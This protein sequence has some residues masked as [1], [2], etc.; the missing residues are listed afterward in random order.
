ML[1][2]CM[3]INDCKILLWNGGIVKCIFGLRFLCERALSLVLIICGYVWRIGC[4]LTYGII[5]GVNSLLGMEYD[6]KFL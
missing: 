5:K 4:N 1:H 3:L 6:N 2:D